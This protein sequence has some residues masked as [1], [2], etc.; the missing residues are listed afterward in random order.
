MTVSGSS[1]KISKL[2]DLDFDANFCDDLDKLRE[3]RTNIHLQN[4]SGLEHS[5]YERDDWSFAINLLNMVISIIGLE[6]ENI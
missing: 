2:R 5:M 4:V 6:Y 3:K 1:A